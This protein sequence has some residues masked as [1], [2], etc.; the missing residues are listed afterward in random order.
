MSTKA[1][2]KNVSGTEPGSRECLAA[3]P[4]SRP[5]TAAHTFHRAQLSGFVLVVSPR[6]GDGTAKRVSMLWPGTEEWHSSAWVKSRLQ[7]GLT[8]ML[9]GPEN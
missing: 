2:E 5:H 9:E 8:L 7:Q 3:V 6:W 1:R 4:E